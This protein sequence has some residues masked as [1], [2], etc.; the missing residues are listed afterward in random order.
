MLFE[1]VGYVSN[2]IRCTQQIPPKYCCQLLN[3]SD[4]CNTWITHNWI[5]FVILL[6]LFAPVICKTN[7]YISI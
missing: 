2:V 1:L 5:T 3:P 4:Y 7:Y 6:P